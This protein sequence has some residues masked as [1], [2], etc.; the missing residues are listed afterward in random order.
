MHRINCATP[1]H[2]PTIHGFP[3]RLT[4]VPCCI[5]AS[6]VEFVK[7]P[8]FGTI[9]VPALVSN[10]LSCT[11]KTEP[12]RHAKLIE[13]QQKWQHN[14]ISSKSLGQAKTQQLSWPQRHGKICMYG[15]TKQSTCVPNQWHRHLLYFSYL[16]YK[17]Y[18]LQNY[19]EEGLMVSNLNFSTTCTNDMKTHLLFVNSYK[20]GLGS[21]NDSQD[22]LWVRLNTC[23]CSCWKCT[24]SMFLSLQ[25]LA[26][27][28]GKIED[29]ILHFIK[30]LCH[31][32]N[33][34]SFEMILQRLIFQ[35][36]F[37]G[38]RAAP[39]HW[40]VQT[41]FGART[42]FSQPQ[43]SVLLG[44][45]ERPGIPKKKCFTSSDPH[46]DISKQPRW[47]H[48][49]CVFQPKAQALQRQVPLFCPKLILS[50]RD[51]HFQ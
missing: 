35:N 36:S 19:F 6:V 23:H 2:Q 45:Q 44:L 48:P 14:T 34:S 1:L 42:V 12:V 26:H 3:S 47:D 9:S 16:L 24:I 28:H 25:F 33:G 31:S 39:R 11:S 5:M 46:H 10:S 49:H 20:L 41:P 32:L 7:T 15:Q 37:L 13:G 30:K 27:L 43:H 8:H 38:E 40:F 17:A 21:K 50:S 51:H 22:T 29:A 4:S 18:G